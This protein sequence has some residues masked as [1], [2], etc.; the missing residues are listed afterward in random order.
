M[1]KAAT[2]DIGSNS[3]KYLLAEIDAESMKPVDERVEITRLSA[4]LDISGNLAV[5]AMERTVDAIGQMV[6]ELKNKGAQKIFLVG[7]MALRHGKNASE[8]VQMVQQRTG[9]T[10]DVLSGVQEAELGHLAV[11]KSL[12]LGT[13][14]HCVFDTGGGS[15]E[16]IFG[17]N[18]SITT[19]FSLNVGVVRLTEHYLSK[20]QPDQADIH[21]CRNR[22]F[23]ELVELKKFRCDQVIGLGGTV[24]TLAAVLHKVQ[25]YD[26]KLV[27]GTI[28][29]NDDLQ[30][31]LDL[32]ISMPLSD[33]RNINGLNPKR[34]DVI[35][36]G[37]I[38]TQV[39]LTHFNR[40]QLM[41]SDSGLRLGYLCHRM[42]CN[43]VVFD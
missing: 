27:H 2:I 28:L 43:H 32:F 21:R 42:N 40:T 33:R 9:L 4:G 24:T 5:V 11:V 12:D 26:P 35:I 22:V 25:P 16:F 3:V 10:I 14:T 23:N 30:Q 13:S 7:T 39:I 17:Q 6:D 38:I 31:L 19:S 41:V 37:L 15:T 8:M 20:D 36:A 29:T 18:S 34:A 1:L